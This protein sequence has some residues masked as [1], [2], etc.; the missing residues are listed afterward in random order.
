M[1]ET[2]IHLNGRRY[3]VMPKAG[4]TFD[5]ALARASAGDRIRAEAQRRIV[6][7]VGGDPADRANPPGWLIRQ[8]NLQA[9]F[10]E[11]LTL[12]RERALTAEEQ[13][14]KRALLALW[15]RIK[16]IRAYSNELEARASQDAS[17]DI[18]LGWPE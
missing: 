5:Q 13:A 6:L 16:A 11:L 2:T 12:E 17:V 4:E 18:Q 7:A 14:Q 9:A 1:T 8:T 15:G 10:S 3:A